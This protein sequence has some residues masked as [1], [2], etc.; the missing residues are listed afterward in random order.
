MRKLRFYHGGG[1]GERGNHLR[2]GVRKGR[3]G[4]ALGTDWDGGRPR[5]L[6]DRVDG[7]QRLQGRAHLGAVLQ[8]RTMPPGT[9]AAAVAHRGGMP[10]HEECGVLGALGG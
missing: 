8:G 7:P 1:N 5:W 9:V 10:G 4:A 2:G 6:P 3:L